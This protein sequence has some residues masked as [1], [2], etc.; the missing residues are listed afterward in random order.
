MAANDNYWWDASTAT[1]VN[2]SVACIGGITMAA[3]R[4]ANY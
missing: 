1:A 2:I 4:D 3:N